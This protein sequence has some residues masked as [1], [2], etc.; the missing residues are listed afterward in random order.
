LKILLIT[1]V[2]VFV[3]THVAEKMDLFAVVY[4]GLIPQLVVE[5]GYVWQLITYSFLHGDLM[6]L[7]FN[8]L[9]VWM[10]GTELMRLWGTKEFFRFYTICAVGGAITKILAA[11]LLIPAIMGPADGQA[12]IAQP[13]IGASGAVYGFLAAYA[14]FFGD[15]MMYVL[16]LFP[17]KAKHVAILFGLISLWSM[18][19]EAPGSQGGIAHSAHLGGMVAG[20]LYLYIRAWRRIRSRRGSETDKAKAKTRFRVIVNQNFTQK[21]DENPPDPKRWN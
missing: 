18:F 13:M 8:S 5:K 4:L 20:F 7:L 9:A 1:Y 6:H 16:F 2:V 21:D 17:M 12:S 19:M 11:Y 15:Q 3:L 14:I 10:F